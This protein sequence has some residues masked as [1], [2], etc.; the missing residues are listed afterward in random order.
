MARDKQ[1]QQVTLPCQNARMK[2]QLNSMCSNFIKTS[3]KAALQM[4]LEQQFDAFEQ[5][6]VHGKSATEK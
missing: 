2:R 3:E 4:K 6:F 1:Y 5:Q